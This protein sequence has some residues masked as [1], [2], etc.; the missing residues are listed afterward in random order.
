MIFYKIAQTVS[1]N[2][3]VHCNEE[4][5]LAKKDVYVLL[6]TYFP[7]LWMPPGKANRELRSSE[8]R[9]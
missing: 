6:L 2:V 1:Y 4:R 8:F 7:D 5:V 3:D 9:L